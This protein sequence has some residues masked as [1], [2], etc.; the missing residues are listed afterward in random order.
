M[1]RTASNNAQVCKDGVCYDELDISSYDTT[2]RAFHWDGTSGATELCDGTD[3]DI[4]TGEVTFTSESDI[5]V[6]I[7]AWQIAYDAEQQAIADAQAQA[8]AQV[9]ALAEETP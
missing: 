1:T 6:C 3:Y 4:N 2:V 7:N 9:E 5:Q 8:Q